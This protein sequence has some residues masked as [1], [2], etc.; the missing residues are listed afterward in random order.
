M[1][2]VFKNEIISIFSFLFSYR[3]QV[4]H[5]STDAKTSVDPHEI[6]K[7]DGLSS[8]WWNE[9]GEFKPLHS[10]NSLRYKLPKFKSKLEAPI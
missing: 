9:G 3:V 2:S 10:M 5:L 4:H 8:L 6:K 1:I 7:F